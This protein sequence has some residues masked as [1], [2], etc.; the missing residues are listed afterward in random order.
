M[1]PRSPL[2]LVTRLLI[3]FNDGGFLKTMTIGFLFITLA[4]M[5]AITVYF[6]SEEQ[7]KSA[8][9]QITTR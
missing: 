1:C 4:V 5:G 7:R 8:F 2:G 6:R 3:E 9:L